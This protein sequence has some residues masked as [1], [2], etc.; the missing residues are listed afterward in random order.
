MDPQ[1]IKPINKTVF[2]TGTPGVGK[3]TLANLIEKKL[4][5]H[6][7]KINQFAEERKLFSGTDKE[8]G[9][10]IIDLD[11]L[12]PEITKTI[13][14]ISQD[15]SAKIVVDGHLSHFCHGADL[16]I[17]L[18]LEP[19]ILKERLKKRN[20]SDS[21]IREN[22]EAESLGV[23]SLEA[24]EIHGNNVHEIDVGKLS[25]ADILNTV[26]KVI[27]GEKSFPLGKIDFL[28]WIVNN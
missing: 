1:I 22:L 18:R 14:E 15:E 3:S 24:Q 10:K 19:S 13:S 23:C 16:V 8:K 6:L 5:W 11:V 27:N 4:S 17:V 7:I 25:P 20:Y 26:T 21:K 28:N 2:I 9:Y 12:C